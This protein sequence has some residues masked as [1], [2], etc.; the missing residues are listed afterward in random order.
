MGLSVTLKRVQRLVAHSSR[1]SC[2]IQASDSWHI[3]L[4]TAAADSI[5][6]TAERMFR[7]KRAGVGLRGWRA[8]RSRPPR[9]VGLLV[10]AGV[11]F[12]IRPEDVRDHLFVL[13]E[14]LL[15]NLYATVT[16]FPFRSAEP[17]VL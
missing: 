12:R 16:D 8:G 7:D 6:R 11:A 1:S 5:E 4:P 3:K 2:S 13:I 17:H 10:A 15:V 9:V 14:M